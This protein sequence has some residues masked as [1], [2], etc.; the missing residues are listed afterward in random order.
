ME[1]HVIEVPLVPRHSA[2]TIREAKAYFNWFMQIKEERI[3]YLR[4][5]CAEALNC[6]V[7]ELDFS[8]ESLVLIWRFFLSIATIEE[9]PPDEPIEAFM[10]P[11]LIKQGITP[12]S[13]FGRPEKRLTHF[14]EMLLIDVGMYYGETLVRN[15][16][17]LKWE[18]HR[19]KD[20]NFNRPVISG[21]VDL[22]NPKYHP[23]VNPLSCGRGAAMVLLT[24]VPRAEVEDA[25]VQGYDYNSMDVPADARGDS[26]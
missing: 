19:G 22:Y 9:M 26:V 5:K 3:Q 15:H 8:R 17:C 4:T 23:R 11:R 6:S 25:L 12:E 20:V 24:K 10:S 14:T 21:F 18:L 16:P 2:M 1:Y 13:L 7:E